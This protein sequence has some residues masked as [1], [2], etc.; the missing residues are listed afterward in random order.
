MRNINKISYNAALIYLNKMLRIINL[1]RYILKIAQS[2][3]DS[4]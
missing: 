1:K 2:F 3:K 4:L